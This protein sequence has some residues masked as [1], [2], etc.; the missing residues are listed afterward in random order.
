MQ[1]KKILMYL[2]T[3]LIQNSCLC[4]Q[5]VLCHAI[6]LCTPEN[7]CQVYFTFCKSNS[8]TWTKI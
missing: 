2:L 7:S 8:Y 5:Q 6:C 3:I 1:N 4:H